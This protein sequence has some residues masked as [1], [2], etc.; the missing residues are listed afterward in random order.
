MNAPKFEERRDLEQRMHAMEERL[1][2]GDSRMGAIERDLKTNTAATTKV[3]DIVIM[4]E[5]F[6]KMMGHIG[7][8]IKWTAMVVAA[9]GGLWTAW[10][11]RG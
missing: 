9:L 1:A 5:G 11:H 6:F 4:G 8:L 2:R 10:T 7:R 3:L